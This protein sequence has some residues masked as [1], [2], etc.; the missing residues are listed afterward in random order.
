MTCIPQFQLFS[1]ATRRRV[2]TFS[3]A[4]FLSLLALS[5]KSQYP[6]GTRQTRAGDEK[7]AR[8]VKTARVEE[9]PFGEAVN[10]NGTL[11]AYDQTTASVKVPG[12]LR[13]ITVDLGSVVRRGQVI[14]QVEP[15]DYNCAYNSRGGPCPSAST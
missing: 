13:S 4:I 1:L 8:Q 6:A 3:F 14:A 9:T 12:R 10:A 11:A 15:Q 2:R 7:A 5:C